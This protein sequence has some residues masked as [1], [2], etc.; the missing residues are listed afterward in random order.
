MTIDTMNQEYAESFVR[1]WMVASKQNKSCADVAFCMKCSHLQVLAIAS[2]LR[3]KGVSLPV[4][5]AG[6]DFEAL[7]AIVKRNLS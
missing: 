7:N 5:R 3:S 2:S 1:A 6:L 4:L